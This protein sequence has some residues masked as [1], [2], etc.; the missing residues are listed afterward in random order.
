MKR[1]LL[2][3]CA[4]AFSSGTTHKQII[5]LLSYVFPSDHVHIDQSSRHHPTPRQRAPSICPFPPVG[6]PRHTTRRH[7][8]ISL[9]PLPLRPSCQAV[10]RR[11]HTSFSIRKKCL[12]LLHTLDPLR[13]LLRL[14]ALHF[15]TARPDQDAFPIPRYPPSTLLIRLRL[16]QNF[17]RP[18]RASRRPL[19]HQ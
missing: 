13:R 9:R 11:S 8:L 6:V 15:R 5:L 19:Y 16:R 2:A 4:T 18:S 17:V 14:R 7:S 10:L 1:H 12:W 3:L